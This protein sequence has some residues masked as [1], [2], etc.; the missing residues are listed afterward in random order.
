MFSTATG[1]SDTPRV[2]YDY[3]LSAHSAGDGCLLCHYTWG[4]KGLIYV[5]ISLVTTTRPDPWD[6]TQTSPSICPL[7]PHSLQLVMRGGMNFSN[8]LPSWSILFDLSSFEDLAIA[9][10]PQGRVSSNWDLFL[11]ERSTPTTYRTVCS[12]FITYASVILSGT[13][14]QAPLLSSLRSA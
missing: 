10:I 12:K 14:T 11:H 5:T 6:W 13:R 1:A 3:Y 8:L 2:A 4:S 9:V 7:P